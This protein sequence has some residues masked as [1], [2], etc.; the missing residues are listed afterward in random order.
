MLTREE[1]LKFDYE[2]F[3]IETQ[4]D[5]RLFVD[6]PQGTVITTNE[7]GSRILKLLDGKNTINQIINEMSQVYNLSE[8]IVG[9]YVYNYIY[10]L[11]QDKLI[12][13]LGEKR[14]E[15]PF[16]LISRIYLSLTEEDQ[17]GKVQELSVKDI[18]KI[19]ETIEKNGISDKMIVHLRGWPFKH[20]KWKK[21]LD[22][23]RSK[24]YANIW[25]YSDN[26]LL[27]DDMCRYIREKV[28]IVLLDIAHYD[29]EKNDILT[30]KG[31]HD[32]F[33]RNVK[34][35]EEYQIECYATVTPRI[36]NLDGLVELHQFV[37]NLGVRGLFIRKYH[38]KEI[39]KHGIDP[40]DFYEKYMSQYK[41]MIANNEFINSWRNNRINQARKAFRMFAEDDLCARSAFSTKKRRHCGIGQEEISIDSQGFIYP[42]HRLHFDEFRMKTIEEF[43]LNKEARYGADMVSEKCEKCNCW[44]ICLGGCRADNY[45]KGI[46]MS[47]PRQDCAETKKLI[48]QLLFESKD[49]E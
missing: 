18:Q 20:S 48:K 6:N 40:I 23:L 32:L 38:K 21:I 47:T 24:K 10:K 27:S 42:C 7:T 13:K 45:F 14:E 34:K 44:I 3:V 22:F 2:E 37:Y 5:K 17:S 8:N 39:E 46:A 29:E 35:C 41:K 1:V 36:E 4:Q 19:F 28:D 49:A 43:F 33:L 31:S 26:M 30:G 25:L 11:Y 12:Y 16:E 15:R 9:D